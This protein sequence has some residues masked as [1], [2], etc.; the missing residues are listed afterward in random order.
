MALPGYD[1][2][3]NRIEQVLVGDYD[4]DDPET[5]HTTQAMLYDSVGDLDGA[6]LAFSSAVRFQP[7][8]ASNWFNLGSA[9]QAAPL[10]TAADLK[11]AL[12]N[13]WTAEQCLRKA[14]E[15]DDA[16]LPEGATLVNEDNIEVVREVVHA[17]AFRAAVAASLQASE[18]GNPLPAATAQPGAAPGA[19]AGSPAQAAPPAPA[20]AAAA[21]TVHLAVAD[22]LLSVNKNLVKY[23]ESLS[24]YGY[25]DTHLLAEATDSEL[26]EAFSSPEVKMKKPHQ[27]LAL[28]GVSALRARLGFGLDA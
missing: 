12:G 24:D 7:D 18:V 25:E 23:S 27:K 16:E 17:D 1:G 5:D 20:D 15:L 13:G 19:H 9:L 14:Y 26:Q 6:L 11:R 21:D 8:K 2:G 3:G 10:P 4:E 28:K 22:W